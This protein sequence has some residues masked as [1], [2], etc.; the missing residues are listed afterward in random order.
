MRRWPGLV[1]LVVVAWAYWP[2]TA[3]DFVIDDYVFLAASRMVSAPW[4]A[5]WQSH[6]YE[7]Y[8]FRPLGVL[9]WWLA[10][11]VFGLDYAAHSLINLALHALNIGLLA[12]LL[13][14]L[15]VAAWPRWGGVALFA[16]APFS[17]GAALWPSNRFDLLA[18]AALLLLAILIR[19]A[20]A[21]PERGVSGRSLV[22]IALCA[23][24]ACW[25]KELAYPVA[26]VLGGLALF[27]PSAARRVGW[28]VFAAVA[29]TVVAA[30]AWRHAMLGGAYA[31]VVSDPL[32]ALRLG[33]VALA[34]RGVVLAG[35]AGLVVL[36]GVL[37][38]ALLLRRARSSVS[39]RAVLAVAT[40]WVAATLVQTPL[41]HLFASMVDGSS[42]GT[43]TFARFYY[44][45]WAAGCALLAVMAARARGS[46]V[47]S[48]VVIGV[49]ASFAFAM[50]RLA[51]DFAGWAQREVRPFAL[52][53]TAATEAVAGDGQG[54]SCATVLLGSEQRHPYFRMFADVTV[55]ARTTLPDSVWRCYVLAESTPWIFVFPAGEGAPVDLPLRPIVNPDGR[56]KADA[57]WDGVRY[58]YRL[59]PTSASA[60][61]GA[62][63][64]EWRDGRFVD[65]T[66]SVQSGA[67]SVTFHDW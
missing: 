51:T 44:A 8:Y 32:A 12:A 19:R 16:L 36:A 61:S 43:V 53:A 5:L 59:P 50:H 56:A 20:L 66:E 67:R 42:L 54:G 25:S 28:R 45:P 1:L 40:V 2:V 6:F 39:V 57:V 58:R 41:A 18:V 64:F 4:T 13:R 49:A 30:F 29:V 34:D 7:P 27:V 35:A 47:L 33:L 38:A 37:V 14:G 55:K 63:Y 26:G 48:M 3:G 24:A 23:L 31:A 17:L 46:G 11:R 15:G 9:S 52:T 60:L 22:A 65:V 62:R 21:T 10:Q